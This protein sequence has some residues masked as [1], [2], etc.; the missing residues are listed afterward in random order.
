MQLFWGS[1]MKKNA[2]MKAPLPQGAQDGACAW[3]KPA[4]Y[5]LKNFPFNFARIF[6][7]LGDQ[8]V[9]LLHKPPSVLVL[10]V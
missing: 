8:A 5:L 3:G 6:D 2:L 10:H 7:D 9:Q 1:G 4:S